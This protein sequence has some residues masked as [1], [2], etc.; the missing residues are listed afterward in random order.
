MRIPII[1]AMLIRDALTNRVL[2]IAHARL[3]T[4]ADTLRLAPNVEF[5]AEGLEALQTIVRVAMAIYS[6]QAR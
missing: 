6:D 5:D 2:E 3:R 4:R 1:Q